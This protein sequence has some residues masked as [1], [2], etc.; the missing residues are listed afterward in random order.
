MR[1]WGSVGTF[2]IV[3]SGGKRSAPRW[4]TR[5]AKY[6]RESRAT[7]MHYCFIK[8]R[9]SRGIL[10]TMET[11]GS[12]CGVR[13]GEQ[14]HDERKPRLFSRSGW[15]C[16][17]NKQCECY[18]MWGGM[19]WLDSWGALEV[20]DLLCSRSAVKPVFWTVRLEKIIILSPQQ[21]QTWACVVS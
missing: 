21:S 3:G 16:C 6:R 20:R 9:V 1:R 10:F 17:R 11:L 8:Q 5:Y 7:T 15:W 12:E 13:P 19:R 18:L 14:R 4:L 2:I